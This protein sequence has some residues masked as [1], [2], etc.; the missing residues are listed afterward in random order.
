ML[1]YIPSS[2]F[3]HVQSLQY[4]LWVDTVG[5]K[6]WLN[7]IYQTTHCTLWQEERQ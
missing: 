5:I 3:S 6:D 7:I 1:A 4:M 2:H